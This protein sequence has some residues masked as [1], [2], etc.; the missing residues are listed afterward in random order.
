MKDALI[1]ALR[2]LYRGIKRGRRQDICNLNIPIREGKAKVKK[3]CRN[4][5]QQKIVT[6]EITEAAT[7]KYFTIRPGTLGTHIQSWCKHMPRVIKAVQTGHG[8]LSRHR[9][10]DNHNFEK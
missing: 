6:E 9:K 1:L 5:K 2:A 3:G 10:N 4:D 8:I 7:M